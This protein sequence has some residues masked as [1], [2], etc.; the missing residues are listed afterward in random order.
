MYRREI[1]LEKRVFFI[2]PQILQND[3][4]ILT[5]LGKAIKCVVF[6]EAHKAKGNHAY[7]EVIRKLNP[8]NKYFR[9]LA[10]SATPGSSLKDVLEVRNFLQI[11]CITLNSFIFLK[12]IHNL[13]ISHLE[14]RTHES[15]DVSPYVFSR[16]LET[17]VVPLSDKIS[18]VRDAYIEVIKV[19]IVS[20]VNYKGNLC[21]F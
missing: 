19:N 13:L 16:S 2:T 3:L 4:N 6:D 15:L 7:C 11:T 20:V 12:V 17:V 8:Q 1:W 10:L 14:I 5:K 18:E 9:V 21:R